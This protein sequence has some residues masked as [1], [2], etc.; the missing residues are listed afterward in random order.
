MSEIKLD[1]SHHVKTEVFEKP[2]TFENPSS[3]TVVW[4]GITKVFY[5]K[6]LTHDR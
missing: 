3:H 6:M 4:T 1:L 5:L 2:H